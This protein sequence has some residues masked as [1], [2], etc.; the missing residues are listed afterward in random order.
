MAD[1]LPVDGRGLRPRRAGHRSGGRLRGDRR[2]AL[3]LPRGRGD[4]VPVHGVAR[5]RCDERVRAGDPADRSAAGAPGGDCM[6]LRWMREM[7]R[8]DAAADAGRRPAPRAVLRLDAMTGD[9]I[10]TNAESSG[11]RRVRVSAGGGGGGLAVRPVSAGE[12]APGDWGTLAADAVFAD[13][14]RSDHGMAWM[15]R[16]GT[17]SGWESRLQANVN[18]GLL[19]LAVF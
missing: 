1:P 16:A 4:A 10:N 11:L 12:P 14:M 7:D 3:R 8:M 15:A 9:W 17:A 13:G 5:R 6:T 18:L 19:V 2:R